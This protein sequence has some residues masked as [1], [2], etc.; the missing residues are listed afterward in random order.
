MA[1]SEAQAGFYYQN[2]IAAQYA[3]DLIEFGSPLRA[4]TFENPQRAQYIDDIIADSAHGTTFVQVKWSEDEASAFTLYN[5]ITAEDDSTSLLA[6]LAQGYRHVVG[7]EGRKEVV[8]F[9][10][11]K[12]G[13]NRQPKQGFS[14]SL[15]E[16][17]TDFHQP[18]VDD[19][20]TTNVRQATAFAE[21]EP[22]LDHLLTG[23]GLR[24]LDELSGFLKC[25]RFRLSQPD[26]D[27][28]AERLRARLATLGIEQQQY[29]TLRDEVVRWSI[30]SQQI[31]P[32]DVR[33]ALGVLDHFVDRVSHRFPIDRQMCVPTPHLFDLL[34]ASVKVLEN[35]FVLVE[36]EPGCGKS[37]ALTMYL[38]A[39][40]DV[41]FGYYCFVPGDRTLGN[42]RLGDD[43][44]VRSVCIGLK[45][46][47][48]D[49]QFPRPYAPHTVSLL[50][51][52]LTALSAAKKRVVFVVDGLDHVDRITRQSLIA[53]PL[54]SVLDG[55]PPHNVLIILSSRYPQ[56]LPTS[57][58]QHVQSNPRRHIQVPRFGRSQ[59][60]EFF[61]L[62]AISVDE[63]LIDLVVEVSGGVPIYLEYLAVHLGELNHYQ[64]KQYLESVPTLRD[65]RIDAFHRH[66]WEACKAD[67]QQVYILA[68]LAAS[69][70]FVTPEALRD[71]LQL[72]SVNA[73]LQSVHHAIGAIRHVLRV[74][75][76]QSVAI[77]HASLAEFVAEQTPHLRNEIARALV[78]WFT[79]HSDTDEAWRHQLRHLLQLG[80]NTEVLESCNDQWL[81]RAWASHRPTS[82]IQQNLDIAWQ[83]ATVE[84]NLLE[85]VRI[86]LMKQ[87][88]ALVARNLD[89]SDVQFAQL[90]LDMGHPDEALRMV[91]D[92]EH[93]QCSS[94]GFAAF[95]L[96]HFVSV[97]RVLPRHILDIGLGDGPGPHS[98]PETM[99]TWYRARV[100]DGD[101]VEA[102][103]E[104][105]NV[106]WQAKMPY[107][108][109]K[110][111]IHEDE[112]RKLNLGLQVAVI[113]EL[114]E[115]HKLDDL[116][117]VRDYKDVPEE[118][119]SA[120]RAAIGLVLG[121]VGETHSATTELTAIDLSCL[122]NEDRR[123][124]TLEL[125]L[126]GLD[127][128]LIR[129]AAAVPPQ[130]P[131]RFLDSRDHELREDLFDLY[132]EF[133]VYFLQDPFGFA[134]LEATATGQPPP[135][136]PFVLALGK[137]ARLWTCWVRKTALG[138]V[139]LTLLKSVVD[140][141]DRSHQT[142]LAH[143][144]GGDLAEHLYTRN[145]HRL[146]EQV[147]GCATSVLSTDDLEELARWWARDSNGNR[148][149][150]YPEATRTLAIR[151]FRQLRDA[152]FAL[153]RELL[154]LAERAAR[155][156]EETSA[157]APGLVACAAAW[158]RCGFANEAQRLWCELLDV[159]CGVYWR[160]D[161]QFNE[162][163]S[164]LEL[165]HKHEPQG[166]MDRVAEQLVLAH[167]LVGTAQSKTVAV[168]IEGL[169]E[170][171]AK[172]KPKL[173]LDAL[174]REEGLVYRERALHEIILA[175]L[176]QHVIDRRLLLALVATMERYQNYT[177]FDE[178]TKP[179]AF[180]V[181]SAAL[182]QREFEIARKAYDFWRHILLVEKD[183]PGE[184]G[185]WA[186]AWVLVGE[187]PADVLQDHAVYPLPPPNGKPSN[188]PNLVDS[189]DETL[190]D[191]LDALAVDDLAKFEAR[192]D[193]AIQQAI[194]S[195][196]RRELD[197]VRAD[198][199]TALGRAAGQELSAEEMQ[200]CDDC[201]TVF[202]EAIVGL[203]S[204]LGPSASKSVHEA[205]EQL[206]EA[207]SRELSCTV[208]VSAFE[209]FFDVDDW[210][211]RF[212]RAAGASFSIERVIEKRLP[213]WIRSAPLLRVDDW[214]QLCHRRLKEETRAAGLLAVAE[215]QAA[216]AP[217]RAIKNLVEAWRGASEFFHMHSQLARCI[218]VKLLEL[219]HD[220]GME[221]LFESFRQ[222]YK[223]FPDNIVYQLG[224]LLDVALKYVEIDAIRLYSIWAAHNRSLAAGLEKKPTDVIWL[225]AETH[226][227][228]Q[229]AWLGYLI[230]LF[231]FPVV[232]VRLQTLDELSRLLVERQALADEILKAWPSFDDG[233]KEYVV[234][235]LTSVGIRDSTLAEHL[236]PGLV[237]LAQQEH[238]RNL[239][240][241]VAE[242]VSLAIRRGVTFPPELVETAQ[243][244]K[245]SPGI[246]RP[247]LQITAGPGSKVRLPP[248]LYRA[249]TMLQDSAPRGEL[250]WRMHV[251]LSGLYP[252]PEDGLE[253]EAAVHREYNINTNFDTIEISGEF[254]GS[255]RTAINRAVQSAVE[256][257]AIDLEAL[258]QIEDVLRLRDPTDALVQR[259]PRPSQVSWINGAL[260]D[261]EFV[262]FADLDGLK[263]GYGR[264]DGEWVTVFECTEQRTGDRFGSGPKRATKIRAIVFGVP[265]SNSPPACTD[266][267]KEV[268][269]GTLSRLRN[270]YRYEL[271]QTTP[272]R[273]IARLAPLV[274]STTRRF[275]GRRTPDLAA[276]IPQF[277]SGLGL[278]PAPDD[279]LGYCTDDDVI[280]VRSIEWQEAF[281]QDRRRH[282]PRSDG[283]LLQI[284]R[285]VLTNIANTLGLDLWAYLSMKRTVDRYKP[286]HEMTWAECADIAAIDQ[287]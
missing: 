114:A 177:E 284:R 220:K 34:D 196:R 15:A 83:A 170:F 234:S 30:S 27:T 84:R 207:V 186:E 119:R 132:D 124:F 155:A 58:V 200:R 251:A 3:L 111:P 189:V 171:I 226:A 164:V 36:G 89:L 216:T 93:R 56:A 137:L 210:L 195:D 229:E 107:G 152:S 25:L 214:E 165:A 184:L 275:R 4:I 102:L 108:Q 218:C 96:A 285:D 190:Q 55:T 51:E 131:S 244:L 154:E 104:I 217:E 94:A 85:F 95:S 276:L 202:A 109:T 118:L 105:G 153:S 62:R 48:P 149:L 167:Q 14:K 49:F 142:C 31:R 50:N 197:H 110:E 287:R 28:M 254:E 182:Q 258:N 63:D 201:V 162:I 175:L 185:R 206:F 271:S 5:L 163:L 77:R 2:I 203:P 191:E 156:D 116:T 97:G 235:L 176:S 204:T 270:R 249:F 29:A 33:R 205:L 199:R 150:R 151:V 42:A 242:A 279:L 211:D 261:D 273:E 40:P 87:K 194:K 228:F 178:E 221:L 7:E 141:L 274:V 128:L 280:V 57:I 21:Y 41:L 98:S 39:R 123:W 145:V 103:R 67:Q 38:S 88:I 278:L 174:A 12:A 188:S 187:A 60:Q 238:H 129:G 265:R 99:K 283:F 179:A 106:Q 81:A 54:T 247:S 263:S 241:M 136:R 17:L 19:P 272:P 43:A 166:T 225:K 71:L 138:S 286:E 66:L 282:E 246:I 148:A 146:Y 22:I 79:Q 253:Q 74:S 268:Q 11:R 73:T 236:L 264:R 35:G 78:S 9:S 45:N 208:T 222:E 259:V 134:W 26:R 117:R 250:E 70:E 20:T 61:R 252:Q 113:R 139:S 133:R 120:A 126:C 233:Q 267:T 13:T 239:R 183:M 6:K 18:F 169:I 158:G 223:R 10:T 227:D 281:D 157:I 277:A 266:I 53:A 237:T 159:A 115:R 173:A 243:A 262:G 168:A 80:E 256:S 160:K 76:A 112:N 121:R 127:H 101:A 90:V 180:A 230:G 255:V 16:F 144:E 269:Q 248:Y 260:T 44:F 161:Y 219:D 8:L 193:D 72:L 46:A 92:G 143:N 130:L 192:L 122:P 69:G 68:I 125:A 75:D 82:E 65:E 64:Q 213:T 37:T 215:R 59:V 209:K 172:I 140:A 232:D 47:F 198:W 181:Y 257:D 240:V 23:S 231:S 91:Y 135:L 1:G 86:G 147:W 224:N 24:D 245:S 52:W 32:D 212:I 100:S